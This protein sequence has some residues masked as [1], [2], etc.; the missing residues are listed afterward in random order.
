MGTIID[1]PEDFLVSL[2]ARKESFYLSAEED[3]NKVFIYS[4]LF[5]DVDPDEI[6]SATIELTYDQLGPLIEG[7]IKL[8]SF[9]EKP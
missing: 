8:K 1:T 6:R 9:V 4:L 7:L 5:V 2:E 3:K